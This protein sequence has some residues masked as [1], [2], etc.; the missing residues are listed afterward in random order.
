ML[1]PFF[2]SPAGH[3]R[4]AY[5]VQLDVLRRLRAEPTLVDTATPPS[6]SHVQRVHVSDILQGWFTYPQTFARLLQQL[7][8]SLHAVHTSQQWQ[9]RRWRHQW[10]HQ[11]QHCQP[12]QNESFVG[13]A[14]TPACGHAHA[15]ENS[16]KISDWQAHPCGELTWSTFLHTEVFVCVASKEA[17]DRWTLA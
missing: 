11:W 8:T 4:C 12:H 13:N 15:T 14:V 17:N 6:P 9:W 1:M 16:T 5:A 3:A 2:L 7:A 10:S